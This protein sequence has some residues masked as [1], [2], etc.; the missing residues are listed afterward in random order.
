MRFYQLW[1]Q[2]KHASASNKW[3]R[4]QLAEIARGIDG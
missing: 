2:R 1:H 3:L 4:R